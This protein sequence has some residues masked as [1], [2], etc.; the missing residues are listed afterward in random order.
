MFA[1]NV[2]MGS[3]KDQSLTG[4]KWSAIGEVS[5]HGISFVLGL[6]I[7]RLL[8]PEDFGV[9]GMLA[10]FM[11]ISQ[12]F[13]NCGFG[14]ALIRKIDRTEEDLCTAFYFNI[15]V[16]LCAYGILF[17]AAPYMA[18]FFNT[19][20]LKDVVRVLALTIIVHSL[21]IVPRA[22]R[23]IQVDFRSQAVGLG[24]AASDGG[25][26]QCLRHLVVCSMVAGMDVFLAVVLVDVLL[27]E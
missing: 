13:V 3:I 8:M 7:A 10:I 1:T 17:V 18:D 5:T 6:V 27:W 14:N 20:V 22:L 26:R 9:I 2:G 12:Q 4:F 21:G 25:N 15:V 16:G 19:P 24:L 11:A 23:T